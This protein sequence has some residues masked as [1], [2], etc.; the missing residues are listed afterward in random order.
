M[1]QPPCNA[2]PRHAGGPIAW[3][4]LLVLLI[5]LAAALS[6]APARAHPHEFIDARLTLHFDEAGALE[7]FGVEWHYD[8]FTSMLI[9]ADLGLDPAAETLGPEEAEI[10]SGFDMNWQPGY[11]GDL[12]PELNGE[13]IALLPPEEG[14]AWLDDGQIVSRHVRR[15]AEPADPDAGQLVIRVYDPEYYIAYTIADYARI[16]GRSNC[17]TRLF[18]ADLDAAREQLDAAIDELYAGGVQDIEANFPAV[19][20]EFADELRLEC[21]PAQEG[22]T[23]ATGG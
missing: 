15:V 10:L 21:S 22:S 17:R 13:A 4:A 7:A 18:G 19:G 20:R 6:P 14:H 5:A 8:A 23:G 3:P 2:P 11:E 12:W 16:E 1:T 9:L